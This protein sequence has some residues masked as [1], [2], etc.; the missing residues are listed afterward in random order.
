MTR[1]K[2]MALLPP[3]GVHAHL[4][5]RRGVAAHLLVD[6]ALDF[7]QAA[8]HQGLVPFGDGVGLELGHQGGVGQGGLGHH[9]EAAGVFIQAVHQAGPAHLPDIL[10]VRAMVHQGIEQS[11]LA[12]PGARMDHQTRGLV[13][14]QQVPVFKEDRQGQ[15][16]G[17]Q[18]AGRGRRHAHRHAVARPYPVGG[19]P[20]LAV[21]QDPPGLEE[22]LGRDRDKP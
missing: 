17:G 19:R 21:D 8:P 3:P 12:V 14:H 22:F 16:F 6:F 13:H 5:A 1:Q 9:D 11:A 10:E 18:V 20:R 15:G 7:R 4:L 2:V